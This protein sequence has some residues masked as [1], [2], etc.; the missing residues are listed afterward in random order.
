[1]LWATF[2]I[3]FYGFLR[4]SELVGLHRS[5]ISFSLDHISIILHQSKTD[6]FRRGCT[7]K[8][9][10][11]SSSTCPFHAID[12]YCKLMGDVAPPASLFQAGRI[13]PLSH[14]TVTN[15]L[16]HLLKQALS[17]LF[18]QFPY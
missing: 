3:A 12:R 1:M 18:K 11:T 13:H 16:R 7:V 6:P 14:A 10:S 4:V 5:D 15:T 8:I 9:F 2:T 17:I